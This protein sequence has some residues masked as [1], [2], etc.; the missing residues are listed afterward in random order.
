MSS[1]IIEN[2]LAEEVCLL[3]MK[4]LMLYKFFEM[5]IIFP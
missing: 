5:K 3:A 2:L 4:I 1:F